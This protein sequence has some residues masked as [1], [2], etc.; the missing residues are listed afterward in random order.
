MTLHERRLRAPLARLR[1]L[2]WVIY[3]LRRLRAAERPV[4]SEGMDELHRQADKFERDADQLVRQLDRIDEE[5]PEATVQ[6]ALSTAKR[7]K[8]DST[9]LVQALARI[10]DQLQP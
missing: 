3:Y 7:V 2:G 1:R 6:L 8:R 5:S 10:R 9:L 4:A